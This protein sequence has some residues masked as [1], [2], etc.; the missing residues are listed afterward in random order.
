MWAPICVPSCPL[1]KPTLKP[2]FLKTF[3]EDDVVAEP[4]GGHRHP[5]DD[6][7]L[8]RHQRQVA[9]GRKLGQGQDSRRVS[10]G[11]DLQR[12][13]ALG[14]LETEPTQLVGDRADLEVH[15][16]EVGVGHRLARAAVDD[17]TLE[18]CRRDH[19]RERKH[20]GR[21]RRA[22]PGHLCCPGDPAHHWNSRRSA[23][24]V[25]RSASSRATSMSRY[26]MSMP[27]PVRPAPAVSTVTLAIRWRRSNG[28]CLHV[29]A[30]ILL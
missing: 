27:W 28:D 15:H 9:P 14:Q 19:E 29:T 7:H 25:K 24:R 21:Q 2:L 13:R 18:G 4:G 16:A 20:D 17:P 3:A 22:A 6:D 11:G 10:G 23:S 26:G 5:F 12:R 30:W 1:P 8:V